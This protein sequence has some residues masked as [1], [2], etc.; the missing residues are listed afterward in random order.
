MKKLLLVLSLAFL[1]LAPIKYNKINAWTT[2]DAQENQE[3]KNNVS[4]IIVGVGAACTI[5]CGAA[6]IILSIKNKN[7]LDKIEEEGQEEHQSED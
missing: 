6:I 7:D 4:K 3:Q 5:A 2:P 1:M